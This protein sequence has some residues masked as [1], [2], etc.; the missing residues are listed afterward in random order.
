VKIAI[1]GYG[2][3]G[4]S[5]YEYYNKPENQITICD[6][7]TPE[8]LPAG[9]ETQLGDSY[10]ANLDQFDQIFRGPAVHPRDIVKANGQQILSKVTTNTN[11]FLKLSPTKNIIGVTGTKGKGTTSTLIAKMLEAMGNRVQLGG[12][13]GIPPLDLLRE[14]IAASDWVVLELANFQL[15]DLKISP[16]IAVCLMVEPEHLDWHGNVEEYYQAKTELFRNQQAQDIAIYY[17]KN[18]NS[19]R[20]ASASGG[21]LIPYCEP[22]GALVAGSH[23]AIDGMP[24]IRL[25]ELKLIGEHNWQN[26][27]AAVTVVWQINQD[28]EA[29]SRVLREFSGLPF[30]IELIREVNGVSFIDDSFASNPS[31]TIA[32]IEAIKSPK[33]LII[34]G[35][36]RGLDLKD[37]VRTITNHAKD[38]RKI[39]LVGEV[40]DKTADNLAK[41]GAANLE[42]FKSPTSMEAIVKRAAEVAENGD[43]VLLS[44]GFPSF[45]M[46]KNFEDRGLK[47]NE[48]VNNL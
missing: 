11:E 34:G 18:P 31:A 17:A 39:L 4:Q 7:G 21:T 35:K 37:L 14:D 32:A 33:V 45:D 2:Q 30:R 8:G 24:I 9:V 20:I 27:C 23:I 1:L 22:P 16:K 19:K 3:Q 6:K 42:I 46:F 15:I 44:P 43:S 38:I 13:I 28:A 36:D 41:A 12:N 47:F 26:V 10:L 40:A 48:A 25:S 29:M 5:V